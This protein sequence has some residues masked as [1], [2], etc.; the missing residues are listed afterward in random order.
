MKI[1]IPFPSAAGALRHS[2]FVPRSP[3]GGSNAP[4]RLGCRLFVVGCSMFAITA[5]ADTA[6]NRL[7]LTSAVL[8]SYSDELRTNSPAIK[9]AQARKTSAES[10]L[11]GVRSWANPDVSLGIYLASRPKREDDGDLVYGVSQSL[12]LWGRVAAERSAAES[13]ILV[14]SAGVDLQFQ[15][16]RLE[17]VR[18]F[19]RTALADKTTAI[20][21]DDLRWLDA[22]VD[23][24]RQRAATG[25]G[26]TAEILRLQ[27]EQD[28]Q[29]TRLATEKERAGEARSQLNRLLG[30]PA[31]TAWPQF[32]L[33]DLG[34]EL[35]FNDRFRQLTLRNEAKLK[36]LNRTAEATAT[37]IE[38]AKRAARPDVRV[39]GELRQ[40]SGSG[41][42]RE[43]MLGVAMSVPWFNRG[44]YRADVARAEA[45]ADAARLDAADYERFVPVEARRIATLAGNARREAIA[46]RDRILPR[47]TQMLEAMR[48]S[49]VS[50][51]GDLISLFDIRR[52]WLDGQR[53]L[54]N[55]TAE[56]WQ[57]LAEITLC[58]GL[59]DLEAIEALNDPAIDAGSHIPDAG[60]K[61]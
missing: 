54:A 28:V 35:R 30:R 6:T 52:Q 9:A 27:N 1:S 47:T 40:Y 20:M 10:R 29:S 45:E 60:S 8:G 22:L 56:Q 25:A 50:G 18:Q 57:M 16:L 2:L 41:E 21:A 38:V 33:P 5:L 49:W 53:M 34:P 32:E 46:Y 36:L 58:C 19:L 13:S 11:A 43:G 24:A 59:A 23:L 17:L 55:A 31:S 42:A 12:P 44:R 4:L 26:A 15:Q 37:G 3:R 61:P 7:K 39:F 48:G 14:A 51:S